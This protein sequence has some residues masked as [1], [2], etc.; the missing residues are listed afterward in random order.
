MAT[1][2]D[3]EYRNALQRARRRANPER[4]KRQAAESKRR[5][6]HRYRGRQKEYRAQRA[7]HYKQ[8]WNAWYAANKE[9]EAARHRVYQRANPE[10]KRQSEKRRRAA[11]LSGCPALLTR[12][13][14]QEI[15][16]AYSQRCAYCGASGQLQQ[17]HVIPLSRG[18]THVRE[19]VVPAC[20]PCNSHKG[21]QLPTILPRI[22]PPL[23]SSA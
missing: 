23:S 10:V 11:R 3:R 22:Y 18:G 13:G 14:W 17:D 16:A 6:W 9:H 2:S 12:E 4:T 21:A 8:L 19:N 15:L 1:E 7:E 5:N 20:A